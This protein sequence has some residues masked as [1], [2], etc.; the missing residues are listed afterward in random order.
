VIVSKEDLQRFL[1]GQAAAGRRVEQEHAHRL[2]LLK[3]E[4][5]LKEYQDLCA[6]WYSRP[7]AAEVDLDRLEA[8]L[9]IRRALKIYSETSSR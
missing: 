9:R 1:R 5:S 8:L 3:P 6:V 7:H 2:P 4:E